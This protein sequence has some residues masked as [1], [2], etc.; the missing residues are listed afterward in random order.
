MKAYYRSQL[1]SVLRFF[2]RTERALINHYLLFGAA[3]RL[4][5][6]HL[7]ESGWYLRKSKDV[8]EQGVNAFAHYL[9]HG[10]IEGRL[11]SPY[12]DI[13]WYL[14][15]MGLPTSSMN[16]LAFYNLARAGGSRQSPTPFFDAAWYRARNP[17]LACCE[18]LFEHFLRFGRYEQRSPNRFFDATSYLRNNPDVQSA[19]FSAADHF[20]LYGSDEDRDPSLLFSTSFY[21]SHYR[22]IANNVAIP[23]AHYISYGRDENR[24]PYPIHVAPSNAQVAVIFHFYYRDTWS[25]IRKYLRNIPTSFDLYVSIPAS[26]PGLAKLV[27]AYYPTAVTIYVEDVGHD[28]LP[29]FEILSNIYSSDKEYNCICKIHTKKGATRPDLWRQLLLESTLGSKW[30]VNEILRLFMSDTELA[31]VGSQDFYISGWE[32]IGGNGQ[33]VVRQCLAL[34]PEK[35]L[36]SSWG[37]F[38]GSMFWFRPSFFKLLTAQVLQNRELFQ[39]NSLSSDGQYSHALE[40]VLGCL[41][42]YERMR[43]GRVEAGRAKHQR[44]NIRCLA[45]TDDIS[46]EPP[47]RALERRHLQQ[48]GRQWPTY[49]YDPS[50]KLGVHLVGP[51]QYINGLGTSVRSYASALAEAGIPLSAENWSWGCDHLKKCDFIVPPK[52]AQPIQ[53]VHLNLD[54]L[55]AIS[56]HNNEVYSSIFANKCYRIIICYFELVALYPEWLPILNSFDEAWCASEFIARSIRAASNIKVNVIRPSLTPALA[57]ADAGHRPLTRCHFGLSQKRYVFGYFL[58]AGSVLRRKNPEALVA[59]Y[60]DAFGEREGAC[61]F[62]KI[63]NCDDPLAL[64]SDRLRTRIGSREDVVLS[65]QIFPNS[66]M[67]DLFAAVDCYVSPHRSEGLGLTIIE[68]M[69]AGKPVIATPYGGAADFVTE[70]TAYP[71]PFGYVEVGEGNPPYRTKCV[72]AE[73]DLDALTRTLRHV[74]TEREEARVRAR[75]GRETVLKLYGQEENA[76]IM[77]ETLDRAWSSLQ[78]G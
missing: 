68:A 60:C 33:L 44:P 78:P 17:D 58:D 32:F 15:A 11:P 22:D 6:H 41:A 2:L 66:S 53:I 9:S 70:E 63:S 8:E 59:A 21:R 16:P 55:Y 50:V 40:R 3:R 26:N 52:T 1:P 72:W 61:C 43:V 37:F 56:V 51:L 18:D 71:L 7:F 77:R 39:A 38:A 28:I 65:N 36:P 64:L 30:L 75:V 73:P 19:G 69:S 45:A 54:L 25:E 4:S 42:V 12:F 13:G 67:S 47:H 23:L 48:P 27:L 10:F 57:L 46:T 24:L 76:R 74:F 35:A 49:E 20:M 62:L 5:P 31:L 34:Y 29:M 14:H